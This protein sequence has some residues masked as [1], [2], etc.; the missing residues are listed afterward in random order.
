MD[1]GKLMW[2][3][4]RA[5]LIAFVL[6]PIVRDIFRAYNVVD[7]PGGRTVHA[8]PTPRVGGVSIAIAYVV[9]VLTFFDPKLPLPDYYAETMHLLPGIIIVFLTGLLDD[10]MN[11]RPGF[12]L[13]GQVAAAGAIYAGGLRIEQIL[14]HP[15]P[16]WLSLCVSIFWLLL[17]TN[18][19]NLIDGLDGLCGGMGFLGAMTL[20][21]AG[22]IRHTPSLTFTMLPLA[23]AL[24]GFL[25][26]N[27]NPATVFLG[28][29]GALTIGFLL[30][31]G[32]MIWKNDPEGGGRIA[33]PLLAM[34]VPLIDVSLSIVRRFLKGR[35]IF[36]ADRGHIHHRLLDRGYSVRRASLTL[37]VMAL[38]GIA[39][40][41][42]LSL[43]TLDKSRPYVIPAFLILTACAMANLWYRE[44]EMA[45]H[46]AF[47]REFSQALSRKMRL[48]DLRL[49]LS[50]AKSPEEWWNTLVAAASKEG[51]SRLE[52]S[53]GEA[54]RSE[55]ISTRPA[56]WTFEV[57][58]GAAGSLRIDGSGS[59]EEGLDLTALP[60]VMQST[61]GMSQTREGHA[62]AVS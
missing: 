29:S 50:R 55:V 11:L 27:F 26:F 1:P 9:C 24:L 49:A 60:A 15:L 4:F 47:R 7:R 28:D 10:F 36:S 42:L 17:T 40:A 62:S 35:P 53:T 23:G 16:A 8:Y 45:W 58:L 39:A 43:G 31:C 41:L 52:W 20:F 61:V 30:G 22:M 12:K 14:D 46:L 57:S 38:P 6:T 5:F 44:L 2:V 19:L 18:A 34:S 48:E 54:R 32:G 59:G 33:V 51:W 37:Y 25:F 56:G 21:A 13:L 3:A